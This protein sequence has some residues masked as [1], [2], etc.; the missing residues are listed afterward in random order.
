MM[1]GTSV[2]ASG[3]PAGKT[4]PSGS[5]GGNGSGTSSQHV[6][7]EIGIRPANC[8]LLTKMN[9]TK[10]ALIMKIKLQEAIKPEGVPLQ[11]AMLLR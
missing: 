8:L 9:Y 1:D 3:S 7:R 11:E 6:V 5:V 10:L 2:A 4:P